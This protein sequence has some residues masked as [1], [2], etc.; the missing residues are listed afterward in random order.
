[1]AGSIAGVLGRSAGL[2]AQKYFG[3][4]KGW[5]FVPVVVFVVISLRLSQGLF[6]D[7][8]P[9]QSI[10]RL[11]QNRIF[12]IIFKYHPEAEQ[13]YIAGF[14]KIL[15]GPNEQ[16]NAASAA[17][18]MEITI[19][20]VGP[21]ML[22]ASDAAIHR[23]LQTEANILDSLKDN[24]TECV[25]QYLGTP[26]ASRA[27]AIPRSLVE[28]SIDAKAEIIESSVVTPSPPP[29]AANIDNIAG[30]IINA[31]RANGY[32]AGEF[33]KIEKVQSL[34]PSEGCEVGRRFISVLASMEEK[35]SS[36]V[37]KGLISAA[38]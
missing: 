20:Y 26:S 37:Y 24:P 19:R 25:A 7:A 10:S 2:I 34:P 36:F 6:E 14:K 11:K 9:M 21:H 23:L 18:G 32:D 31:Y 29:K 16:V 12:G 30:A 22:T 5:R 4:A 28:A 1:V 35:Q 8:I 33:A 13:E 17:L 15:S 27:K 38:K 3:V